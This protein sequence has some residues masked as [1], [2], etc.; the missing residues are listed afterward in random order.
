MCIA[1]DFESGL[2]HFDPRR[3]GHDHF[4]QA[5]ERTGNRHYGRLERH[6]ARHGSG[7]GSG[8]CE[9]RSR[10]AQRTSIYGRLDEVT[11]DDNRRVFDVN[12]WGVVHGSLTALHHLRQTGGAIINVGSEV[13]EAVIPLQGI[14]SASK[15]AVKGFTD[16]L[17]V[18]VEDVDKGNVVITLIQPTAV[19]TP[20]PQHAKNYLAQEPKL[21][22]P[23]ID[24]EEVAEAI[25]HAAR[26]PTRDKKVGGMAVLNTITSKLMP[27]LGDKLAA[28][29]VDQQLAGPPL[30]DKEGALYQPS[31][32]GRVRGSRAAE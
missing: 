32:D 19:N 21:P 26:Y 23:Q 11:L 17:R 28:K 7:C 31:E 8:R 24:P 13:S 6:W 5:T 12:F 2:G 27:G 29:K 30:R 1:P 22:E 15:H 18:E 14:Y 9:A 20:Y 10:L 16:A 3:S 25:L 4:T